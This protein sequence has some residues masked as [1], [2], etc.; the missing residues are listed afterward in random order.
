[1]YSYILNQI[2]LFYRYLRIIN[3]SKVRKL[4][5][6]FLIVLWP[7]DFL[8]NYLNCHLCRYCD[9]SP[10]PWT[11]TRCIKTYTLTNMG[12]PTRRCNNSI[13]IEF[14]L[15]MIS[16][17]KLFWIRRQIY[18]LLYPFITYL[19]TQYVLYTYIAVQIKYNV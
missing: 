5:T 7:F 11:K 17:N 1:M 19:A 16:F 8:H 4:T 6:L 9:V 10:W 12:I 18:Y 3:K 14:S 13:I 15:L 2:V